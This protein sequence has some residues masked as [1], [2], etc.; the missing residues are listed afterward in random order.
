[1]LATAILI[2]FKNF[3]IDAAP[4]QELGK[5]PL[6]KFVNNISVEHVGYRSIY[7]FHFFENTTAVRRS[8]KGQGAPY[9]LA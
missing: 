8:G 9:R 6:C 4:S 7:P 5:L 1:M 2:S 3:S